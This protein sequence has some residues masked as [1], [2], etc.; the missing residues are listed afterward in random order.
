MGNK[1]G[2]SPPQDR[3]DD[4]ELPL[5]QAGLDIT[6]HYYNQNIAR[7][8]G[9]LEGVVTAK[10]FTPQHLGATVV[11]IERGRANEIL[12]APWQT[13]TCI[14][15]WHYSRPLFERHGYKSVSKIVQTLVDVAGKNGNLLLNIP[16]RGDG[17]IDEDEHRFLADLSSWMNTNSEAMASLGTKSTLRKR[18]IRHVELLGSAGTLTFEQGEEQL[19]V[20]LPPAPPHDL[21]A[22]AMRMV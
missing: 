18:P 2:P 19:T 4:T 3:F 17:T 8:E 1:P 10:N 6:A 20:T 14:G 16:V 12:P 7:H 15:D 22:Y 5:G 9:N 21:G 11:D 13:D